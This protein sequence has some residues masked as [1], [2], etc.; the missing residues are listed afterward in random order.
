MQRKLS[1][2]TALSTGVRSDSAEVLVTPVPGGVGRLTVLA[3]FHTLLKA[4]AR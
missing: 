1:A 3:L 2:G 4:T